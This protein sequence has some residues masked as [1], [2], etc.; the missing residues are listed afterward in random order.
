VTR[1]R[2]AK[3]EG[4]PEARLQVS[5]EGAPAPAAAPAAPAPPA[6][7]TPAP[8]APSPGGRIEFG[9]TGESD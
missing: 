5:S 6:P 1:E 8:A 3:V 9:I 2:L 7:P 4:I